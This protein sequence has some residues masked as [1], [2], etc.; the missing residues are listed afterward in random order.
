MKIS[1]EEIKGLNIAAYIDF[2]EKKLKNIYF[3]TVEYPFYVEEQTQL[4]LNRW[5]WHTY[6]IKKEDW[7]NYWFE[8]YDK[9]VK[10]RI[11]NLSEKRDTAAKNLIEIVNFANKTNSNILTKNPNDTMTKKCLKIAKT[12]NFHD[13]QAQGEAYRLLFNTS[14]EYEKEEIKKQLQFNDYAVAN[15]I[16]EFEERDFDFVEFIKQGTFYSGYFYDSRACLELATLEFYKWLAMY[17]NQKQQLH[18][19]TKTLNK[20]QFTELLKALIETKALEYETEKQAV[21]A[22]ALAFNVD[23]EKSEF[24]RILQ[25]IKGR[26]EVTETKFLDMLTTGLKDWIKKIS[27]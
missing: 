18:K 7:N 15:K 9:A 3:A 10:K 14:V 5:Q 25:K 2:L 13:L 19:P 4:A 23:I 21:E 22:L 26:N 11:E 16:K 8:K 6:F 12:I 20:T 1:V 27:G 24:D 17:D